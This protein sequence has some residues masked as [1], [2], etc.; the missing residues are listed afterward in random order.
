MADVSL[1]VAANIIEDVDEEESM[2][3]LDWVVQ[4]MDAKYHGRWNS[5]VVQEVTEPGSVRV[6]FS[7]L[8]SCAMLLTMATLTL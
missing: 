5:R 8:P 1:E 7:V 2:E 3:P 6:R 4:Q